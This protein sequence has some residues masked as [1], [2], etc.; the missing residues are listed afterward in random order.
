MRTAVV[1]HIRI[2]KNAAEI[3]IHKTKFLLRLQADSWCI[4][5]QTINDDICGRAS[6]R[7][8]KIVESAMTKV[9]QGFDVNSTTLYRVLVDTQK[10]KVDLSVLRTSTDGV[11]TIEEDEQWLTRDSTRA[12][13]DKWLDDEELKDQP[14]PFVYRPTLGTVWCC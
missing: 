10:G 14:C 9:M 4:E 8:I 5:A 1:R 13:K 3:Y 12:L 2:A 6:Q 11:C 7:M